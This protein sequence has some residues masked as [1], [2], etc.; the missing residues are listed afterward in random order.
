MQ[1]YL[2]RDPGTGRKRFR[3]ESVPGS[4]ADAQRRLT[5]I[6]REMDTGSTPASS[7]QMRVADYLEG[8]LRDPMESRVRPRTL[9]GYR[10]HVRFKIIPRIGDVRLER[11]TPAQVQEMES[12]LLRRGRGGGLPLSPRTVL[13]TH[14]VLSSALTHALRMGLV[15]RNVVSAVE[16]PRFSR[17]EVRTLGWDESMSLIGSVV[18]PQLRSLFL[19]AIQTGL[20]RSELLGLQWGDVDLHG[21]SLSVRRAL[22]KLPSGVL[23]LK[24]P[25]SGRGRMVSL[26]EDSVLALRSLQPSPAGNGSFVFCHSGGGPIDPTW[27]SRSFRRFADR[28]GLEGLRF[29]DLRHTHASLLLTEGVHP[30]VVSERLGHSSIS[31]TVDTYSHIHPTVQ[32]E[33]VER[34]GAAW[35]DAERRGGGFDDGNGKRNGKSPP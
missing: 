11:L 4:F 30:K 35:S 32:R 5:E 21:R 16:P 6:L 20:R 18:H 27:V 7:G 17:Y 26:V 12:D 29:H 28:A 10:Q 8:W 22:V 33:A 23:D 34:F 19:L 31:I 3:S 9:E 15:S 13:Q 25:K 14:R 1:V 24:E 2:G